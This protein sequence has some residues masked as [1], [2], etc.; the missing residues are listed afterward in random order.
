M[1]TKLF[2]ICAFINFCELVAMDFKF[3]GYFA[4]IMLLCFYWHLHWDT[5]ILFL[6]PPLCTTQHHVKIRIFVH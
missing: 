3:E 4:L 1:S 6:P 2:V 5:L